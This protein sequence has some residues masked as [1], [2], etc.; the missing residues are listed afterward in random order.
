MSGERVV[1]TW[2][3]AMETALLCTSANHSIAPETGGAKGERLSFI[4]FTTVDRQTGSHG[5]PPLPVVTNAAQAA[6]VAGLAVDTAGLTPGG[7][8]GA[9]VT[10]DWFIEV[11]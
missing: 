10:S 6:V 3:A 1:Q 4:I 9:V 11:V 2:H 5:F 7:G 8:G